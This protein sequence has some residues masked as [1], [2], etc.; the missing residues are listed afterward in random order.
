MTT[1][2]NDLGDAIERVIAAAPSGCVE[3]AAP[4]DDLIRALRRPLATE[5]SR[6]LLADLRKHRCFGAMAR[7]ADALASLGSEEPHIRRQHAQALIEIGQLGLAVQVL[8]GLAEQ[9]PESDLRERSEVYG[10]LGRAYKQR[11]VTWSEDPENAGANLRRAVEWYGRAYPL[12]PAWHGANLVALTHRAARD[13]IS[14]DDHPT[15]RSQAERVIADLRQIPASNWNAWTH[16]AVGEAALALENWELARTEYGRFVQHD[17]VDGFAVGSAARQ[18]REIWCFEPAGGDPAGEI[19]AAIETS[20]LASS[21]GGELSVSPARLAQLSSTLQTASRR[22]EDGTFEAIL[23]AN[24]TVPITVVQKLLAAA[25]SVCQVVDRDQ[26]ALK[27]PSGGT[28]FLVAGGALRSDWEGKAL[29][30]TNNHVLSHDGR[31]PSVRDVDA[32]VIFHFLGGH[33]KET[34]FRI[35]EVLATSPREELDFAIASLR[36]APGLDCALPGFSEDAGALGGHG[37]EPPARV[38]LVGHPQGRGIELSLSDNVVLDHQLADK[39][40]QPPG[41]RR[42]HY[43][44]PTESGM[45]G[46]P[47]LDAKRLEVVGLHRRGKV[48][49]LRAGAPQGYEANEAVWGKSILDRIRALPSVP[50]P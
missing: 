28:G 37:D 9:L 32:D 13:G 40:P 21:G 30:V 22:D 19:V 6:R 35:D 49:P 36:E 34:N 14:L 27:T 43:K 42:I 23:G 47:V 2:D 33:G 25:C 45:S 18:L 29:L 11:F 48:S 50:P 26:Q 20:I 31:S 8:T 41:C 38:Y 24:P 3:V 7:L 15:A 16:A 1:A 46:S 39:N 4:L 12:D 44:A 5:Q 17:S 10:L